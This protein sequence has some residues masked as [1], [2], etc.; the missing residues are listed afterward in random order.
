MNRTYQKDHGLRK[1]IVKGMRDVEVVTPEG[2][3]VGNRIALETDWSRVARFAAKLVR[4]LYW[5]EFQEPLPLTATID[6]PARHFRYSDDLSQ[7]HECCRPGSKTWP[8]TFE[9]QF[10]RVENSP[11]DSLWM[12]LLYGGIV[13][14]VF[15]AKPGN[16]EGIAE[17]PP[18]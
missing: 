6:P 9:Y 17:Q 7:F 10:N 13:W 18:A 12:F 5:H 4:G 1:L 14:M 3:Y 2:L 16:E 11:A 8:H 15:T